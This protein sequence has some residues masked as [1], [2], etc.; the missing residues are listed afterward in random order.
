[1][2][3]RMWMRVSWISLMIR[4]FPAR[5]SSQRN[6]PSLMSSS[7]PST[8][9]PCMLPTYLN[10]G[11]TGGGS[12]E[13]KGDMRS[14]SHTE[15]PSVTF[16][17]TAWACSHIHMWAHSLHENALELIGRLLSFF[18][19]LIQPESFYESLSQHVEFLNV[20]GC[21]FEFITPSPD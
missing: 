3:G 16:K 21:K 13:V 11:S 6:W 4:W 12:G 7:R 17:M 18:M 8:S 2:E 20:T 15:L 1:M 10:S 19:F 9:L 5:Y 14:K